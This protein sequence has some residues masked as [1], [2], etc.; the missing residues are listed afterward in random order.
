MKNV[1]KNMDESK[2]VDTKKVEI[3]NV[4][5]RQIL[6]CHLKTVKTLERILQSLIKTDSVKRIVGG[7]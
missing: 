1:E 3:K 6:H 2:N 4:E 7:R 5:K